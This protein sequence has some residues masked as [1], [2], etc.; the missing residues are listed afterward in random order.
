VEDVRLLSRCRITVVRRSLDKELIEEYLSS[1]H[2]DMGQCSNFKD[3]QE[4]T[5]D[6]TFRMPEGFCPS[7]W[8]DIRHVALRV[9]SGG[10]MP[11]MRRPGVEIGSCS[12]WFRPVIFRI[13]RLE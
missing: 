10:N 11:G 4:F 1:E 8:A 6:E 9:A 13:E 5:V 12:D 2:A 3:G 7:A